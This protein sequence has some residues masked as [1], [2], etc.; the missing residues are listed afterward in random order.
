MSVFV[1]TSMFAAALAFHNGISRYLF[2]LGR[3]GVLPSGLSAVHP[4]THAPH[5]ASVTQT[6]SML[7]L[8]TP[9]IIAGADPVAT[10]FFWG[11]GV[12]VVGIVALYALT[13]AAAF[14]Y[15]RS[16]REQDSRVWHTRVAPLLSVVA[17]I[18]TL[19]LVLANIDTLVGATAG[20]TTVLLLTLPAAFLLGF[21][22]YGAARQRL[23]PATRAGLAEELS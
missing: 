16:H 20:P 15:F 8:I 9:F 17:M 6:V 2:T 13:S 7:V 12:A 22:G 10:L 4:R 23:N 5:V 14:W 1:I 3:D 21:A 19:A 18:G 11:S